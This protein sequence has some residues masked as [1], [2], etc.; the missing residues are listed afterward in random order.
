MSLDYLAH[1]RAESARLVEVL[2]G[3]DSDAVVPTCPGWTSADLLWHVGGGQRFWAAMVADAAGSTSQAS[4]SRPETYPGLL[5]FVAAATSLLIDALARTADDVAVW[6][7][8]DAHQSVGFVRRQQTHEALIHRLDAELTAG[9]V[10]DVDAALATDGVLEAIEWMVGGVPGWAAVTTA[11]GPLGRLA[12]TDTAANWLVQVGDWSGTDP[13]THRAHANA[14]TLFLVDA[15]EP[16]FE[17]TGT[18]RDLDAWM[19]NRPTLTE[20]H[21][22]GDTSIFELVLSQGV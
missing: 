13:S 14:P 16:S 21:R 10:T 19:W 3:V 2:A 17:I 7:W 1:L 18:A 9:A 22:T 11:D 20:I 4:P 12:T 15:G 8:V 5:E 6:T